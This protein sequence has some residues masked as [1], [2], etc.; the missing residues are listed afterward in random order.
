M[1]Q[2]PSGCNSVVHVAD[3]DQSEPPVPTGTDRAIEFDAAYEGSPPWDIGHP[4]P[5]FLDLAS[6]GAVTGRAFDVGCGTG[7]H[8]LLAAELGLEATG[9]DQSPRAIRLAE[10]KAAYGAF[11]L[12]SWWETR[13]RWRWSARSTTPSWIVA[14][15]MSSTTRIG[16]SWSGTSTRSSYPVVTTSCS[17]SVTSSRAT[18]APDESARQKSSQVRQWVV[19]R[20]HRRVQARDHHRSAGRT[21][22][23]RCRHP[24][25][26]VPGDKAKPSVRSY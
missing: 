25:L 13:W 22:L 3:P 6:S 26:K 10:M 4:Q 21:G 7:E 11:P 16:R 5:A 20:C 17:A 9:P 2:R 1:G 18:G 19:H 23:A 8:A 15:S 12:D 24:S 14:S